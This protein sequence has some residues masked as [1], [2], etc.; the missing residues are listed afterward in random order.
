[1]GPADFF[2]LTPSMGW[3]AIL[4]FLGGMTMLALT[5]GPAFF[6]STARA[7]VGGFW[8]G[9]G[10]MVGALFADLTYMVLAVLGMAWVATQ[11][12]D[13][14]I[15]VKII[16]GAFLVLM[17]LRLFF[18]SP[19][20]TAQKAAKQTSFSKAMFEGWVLTISNP[21]V[22]VFYASFVPAFV[23]MSQVTIADLGI[24]IFIS[25]FPGS[26]I[27][28]FYVWIAARAREFFKNPTARKR[29]NY[30]GGA[31]LMAVG[32]FLAVSKV[33]PNGGL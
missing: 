28:F 21:K 11:M 18:E 31:V 4:A 1:M 26:A 2:N 3:G 27:D 15:W 33:T 12:G 30:I 5:P 19:E 7:L 32:V 16:G 29:L 8:N 25:L 9:A 20:K 22:L 10:I 14:F 23:D 17:G 13:A 6:A 24:M